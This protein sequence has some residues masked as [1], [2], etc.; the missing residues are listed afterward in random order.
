M[1]KTKVFFAAL[2]ACILGT[3]TCFFGASAVNA[4]NTDA[5]EIYL[6]HCKTCHGVDGEPTDLGTGLGAR[7]FAD[8]EW[9][10]KT[11]DERI[12]E[13]INEGTPDMMMGFKEKLTPEE[14]KA[15]VGVIRGFK[16]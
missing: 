16:K 11:T 2:F 4:S 13:Q 8:Q 3:L 5:K 10:E 6:K 9:Q 14:I 12:I 7:R 1:V 15:L